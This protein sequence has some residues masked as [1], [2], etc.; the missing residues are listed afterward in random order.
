M[1]NEIFSGCVRRRRWSSKRIRP[2]PPAS[3]SKESLYQSSSKRCHLKKGIKRIF[4]FCPPS[5]LLGETNLRMKLT[6]A[7]PTIDWYAREEAVLFA[8][9]A[10]VASPSPLNSGFL[11]IQKSFS[12]KRRWSTFPERSQTRRQYRQ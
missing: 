6:G 8:S 12:A 2:T 3:Y 1:M 4:R 5:H 7:P 9:C 10:C 11:P